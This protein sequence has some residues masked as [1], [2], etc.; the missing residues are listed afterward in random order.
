[1]VVGGWQWVVLAT[2]CL[3]SHGGLRVVHWV[4]SGM[5]VVVVCVLVFLMCSLVVTAI[6]WWV[7]A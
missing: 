2:G 4:T 7:A 1:M 6:A 5:H 3:A